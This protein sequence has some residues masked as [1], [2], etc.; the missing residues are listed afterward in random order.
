MEL[1]TIASSSSGNAIYVGNEDTH[2]LVDAGI[3]KKKISKKIKEFLLCQ[4]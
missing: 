4:K 3:S 2:L 1:C